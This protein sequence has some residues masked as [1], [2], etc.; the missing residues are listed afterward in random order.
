M[1]RFA[2]IEQAGGRV[3]VEELP[4]PGDLADQLPPFR[5]EL[6]AVRRIARR[7]G[8][9]IPEGRQSQ[10][11]RPRLDAQWLRQAERQAVTRC[12]DVTPRQIE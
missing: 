6:Q 8:L 4:L 5:R 3:A 9:V 10:I 11:E 1:A 2:A 12:E 7:K